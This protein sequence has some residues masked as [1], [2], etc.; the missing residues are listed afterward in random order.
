MTEAQIYFKKTARLKFQLLNRTLKKGVIMEIKEREDRERI[1]T[2]LKTILG[3]LDSDFRKGSFHIRYEVEEHGKRSVEKA[4]FSKTY[5]R[6][7]SS[8]FVL[9]RMEK[10]LIFELKDQNQEIW[11]TSNEEASKGIKELIQEAFKRCGLSI[12][13]NKIITVTKAELQ[14]L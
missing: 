1:L 7:L 5:L 8:K 9:P 13:A 3:I 6:E 12:E 4:I 11:T 14:K 2:V 10:I